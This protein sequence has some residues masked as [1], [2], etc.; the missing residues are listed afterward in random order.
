MLFN[1]VEYLLFL[2][3]T[4]L[5]YYLLPSAWRWF[6]LLVASYFFYA[7]WKV[8]YL[9]LIAL[10]TLV[11]FVVSNRLGVVKSP[12]WR[13]IW[14]GLS[15]TT[16]LGLLYWFK[17][18]KLF[19]PPRE[20]IEL[21]SAA[22]ESPLSGELQFALYM[23]IPV[24][25]SFYTFQTLSYTL[26]VYFG[27]V[28]PE[29]HLG[30]FA[31]FVSFFPQLVA[32]PI[33]RFGHLR[34]QLNGL[35]NWNWDDIRNGLRLILFGFFLKLCIAD[36]LAQTVDPVYASPDSY[37]SLNLLLGTFL[38]GFQIYGDFA[39][40]S[41]IAQGSALLLGIR[42]MDNFRN[43]Y[44]STSISEFWQRWHISLSTWFRDY[45]YIPLG[46]NRVRWHRWILNILL[47]FAVSGF[48]HGAEWTFVIWGG[49]HGL[50]YLLERLFRTLSVPSLLRRLFGWPFTF[51]AVSVAWVFFRASDMGAM[52]QIWTSFLTNSG[53]E[54]LQFGAG[55]IL[56]GLLFLAA[57][58]WLYNHRFDRA[59]ASL[60]WAVRWMV[61]ALLLIC[62]LALGGATNHPFIYFQF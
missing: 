51:I 56:P 27:R 45:L 32:G 29:T 62:I 35:V 9:A 19:L 54:S 57:E 5:L 59:V 17:Y 24:G 30:K 36:N 60:H 22:A 26:D 4:V 28:K 47:V 48:W 16:N 6:L 44:L 7:S 11:D 31:L 55:F 53:T 18:L 34:P 8:E 61:Y 33:E 39:G 52:G 20:L 2:P 38:F 41:L 14:L 46:G 50:M 37:S 3:A 43:P 42:L 1:S 21:S 10:S 25:I 58:F 23:V 49:I 15:L 40:Y 12:L 13:K